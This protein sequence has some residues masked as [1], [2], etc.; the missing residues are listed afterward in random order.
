MKNKIL[1]KIQDLREKIRHQDH[2]YYDLQKP[3]ISDFKYDQ[4]YKKLK[5]L[6]EKYPEFK[7]K[8]SPTQKVP[9]K[10]L[11]K[12][13][14]EAHRQK[15]FSLQN[16][17][18]KEDIKDFF[19]KSL[20]LLKEENVSCV[21]EPKLDGVA[22]ELIYEK[23]LLTKALSRGDGETGENITEN[24][25]TI[26]EIP[27]ELQKSPLPSPPPLLEVRGEVFI[28]KKDFKQIN[29]QQEELGEPLFSNPRNFAAGTLRQ[30]DSRITATRPLHFYSHGLGAHRGFKI[31]N[32]KDFIELLQ[33]LGLPCLS[34]SSSAS[35]KLPALCRLSHSLEDILDYYEDM[36][37]LRHQFPFEMDGIVIKINSFEQQKHLGEIARHP[38]WAIAGK[39]PPEEKSTQI[40][41]IL[42]QVGRTG[43]ITPVALMKPVSL[44]GAW[45]RQASL[46]N[47]KDLSRKD[48]RK[49]DFVRVHRAGDVIPEIL[50]P[51]KEKR[52]KNSKAVSAP[53]ACPVCKT[54]LQEDGDY[55]RC[56]NSLCPAVQE[57]S[58]IHFAS[59]K[60]M[61]IEFLGEKSI[62]KFYQKGWLKC[63]S[64][65]YKLSQKP[66]DQEEGFGK[67]SF[68]LLLKSLE[69]SKKTKVPR[70]LFALGIPHVGEQTAQIVS[71][72]LSEIFKQKSFHLKELLPVLQNFKE[73]DFQALP[74]IG[75]VAASSLKKAFEKKELLK[76]LKML[77]E[78]G[79]V[80]L[81]DKKSMELQGLKFVITGTLPLPREE[82]KQVLEEK[83]AQVLSQISQ[84]TDYVLEGENPGSKKKKAEDLK[85]PLLNWEEF[86]KLL[87]LNQKR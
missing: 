48:I 54:P 85:I 74:D 28:L 38:R 8:D 35:L 12:F 56:L 11:E 64:D 51:L 41:E 59:K 25:K 76:D 63:F 81:F 17:Y 78:A 72:K 75:P 39:F 68:E 19:E 46:H 67:K 31:E 82:I 24:I 73:E 32:Q 44:G 42:F 83:G 61:N 79:V 13:Q 69:K 16:S 86:Q 4:M 52:L 1:K 49:G 29:K 15:M 70:L 80:F 6:E 62:R 36:E 3:E 20:K 71:Q 65:F 87:R 77:H 60:A 47:F 40:E 5:V 21:L 18:S 26:P 7:T 23:G 33:K 84:K 34:F 22:V 58:L 57:C 14:K 9:G 43:V 55:L 66:L 2:L 27:Q 30:L 37:S 45:I 50:K 53:K 10:V